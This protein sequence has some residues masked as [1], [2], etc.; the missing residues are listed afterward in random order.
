MAD[1]KDGELQ[2]L[3]TIPTATSIEVKGRF[4]NTEDGDLAILGI[5]TLELKENLSSLCKKVV[6][7]LNDIRAVGDFQLNEV[8]F[9]IEI[10]AEAGVSL[11]GTSKAGGKG[12]VTLKFGK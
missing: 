9:Q 12:G 2:V 5:S 10:S 3:V 7:I 4:F 6:E 1:S 11:I 8:S